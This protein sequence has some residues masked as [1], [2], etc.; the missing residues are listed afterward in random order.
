MKEIN[1][2]SKG[3]AE[4]HPEDNSPHQGVADQWHIATVS[5]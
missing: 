5:K 2:F 1:A 4:T 3:G